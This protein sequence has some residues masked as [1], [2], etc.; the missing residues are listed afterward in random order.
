MA[1][2]IKKSEASR[3]CI[4]AV[5]DVMRWRG[6][7]LHFT[8]AVH[9]GSAILGIPPADVVPTDFHDKTVEA[10]T[11]KYIKEFQRMAKEFDDV[12]ER[13]KG[14]WIDA[15]N[16]NEWYGYT[17]K[18]SICGEETIG[19]CDNYCPYCGAD[20]RADRKE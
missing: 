20:M 3:A 6:T 2:Y 5:R 14:E 4:D 1:E 8:E 11:D 9:I 10:I 12:T 15:H 17:Y 18:C 7:F 13:K 16:T 19:G